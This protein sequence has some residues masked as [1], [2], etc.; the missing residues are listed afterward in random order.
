[1]T[2]E[3]LPFLVRF[4]GT[5]IRWGTI[6]NNLST[7][8]DEVTTGQLAYSDDEVLCDL[9]RCLAAGDPWCGVAGDCIV[10]WVRAMGRDDLDRILREGR[11]AFIEIIGT[12]D[13]F[14]I[15]YGSTYK[16]GQQRMWPNEEQTIL[17]SGRTLEE[18]LANC[19]AVGLPVD[20]ADLEKAAAKADGSD[21]GRA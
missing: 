5:D 6:T 9:E 1:M 19:E 14:D 21:P 11:G 2:S 10:L 18:L 16:K 17:V 7:I 15:T 8:Y 4:N 13:D 12:R 3:T 20:I